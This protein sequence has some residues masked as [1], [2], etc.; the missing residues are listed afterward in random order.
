MGLMPNNREFLQKRES[1]GEQDY[2]IFFLTTN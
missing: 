2:V 1:N